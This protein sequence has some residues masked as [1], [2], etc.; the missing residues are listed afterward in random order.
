[1][2][3][4]GWPGAR[5]G[6]AAGVLVAIVAVAA[7]GSFAAA[8]SVR[9]EQQR[10]QAVRKEIKSVEQKLARQT[11]E[12][13]ANARALRAAE[14]EI[15]AAARKLEALRADIA[16]AEREQRSLEERTARASRQLEGERAELGR[17]ARAAYMSGRAEVVKLLL[18][19]DSPATL[20]RM[21]V[22]YDYFNRARVARI[23]ALA[24][25]MRELA[26]LE[27]ASDEGRRKLAGLAAAQ[28]AEVASL[29][30]ARDERRALVAK[31][32]A[33][34]GDSTAA[35]AKLKTE[36]RRV[37]DLVKQLREA[38]AGFPV[39]TD[40]PFARSKG[41]LV[42]PVPGRLAGDY[43][44]PRVGG[45]LKWNGV[46]L[47][48][49]RGTPVRAIYPGRVAF[50]DWL[51]GLGLLLI[52]DHGGGYMSLYGHNEALLKEPGDRVEAGEAVA[53]VGDS[54]GQ[55]R[56]GLYFEIRQNGE[57]VNP[58]QWITRPVAAR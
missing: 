43:G 44:Q 23:D 55:G 22:Y 32:D 19:Q 9:D 2:G 35:I 10:L 26:A 47:E 4:D 52:V 38:T 49:E 5:R 31:L 7:V 13:D 46:L 42:W 40:Q 34:I 30:R 20:G 24:G 57:P 28:S 36:E 29:E 3:R 6:A 37:S 56:P 21:L 50:A 25:E 11:T 53:R 18:S 8:Q 15:A 45:Q 12:R 33:E 58:H 41:K 51:P 39:D 48:A 17:Q 54:G 27:A 16:T 1:M 14:T